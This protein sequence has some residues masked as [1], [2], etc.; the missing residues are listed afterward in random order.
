MSEYGL[1][2]YGLGPW[3]GITPFAE[4]S[5]GGV[6]VTSTRSV[7][8]FFTEVPLHQ[9][10]IIDKDA[11]NPASW[12]ILREDTGGFDDF[13]KGL[14]V[15][16]VVEIAP[17]IFEIFTLEEFG[18]YAVAHVVLADILAEDGITPI[19]D[20]YYAFFNGLQEAKSGSNTEGTIDIANPPFAENVVAGTLITG[21]DGDYVNDGG[22]PFLRKL[23][24]RR[25]CALPGGFF[26][27]DPTYGLGI[28]VKEPLRTTDLRR[29]S[30]DI[31]LQVLQEPEF[32]SVDVKLTINPGLGVL[33]ILVNAILAKSNRQ[34]SLSIPMPVDSK[35][36]A[37]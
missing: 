30:A 1:T 4:I 7:V 3:G 6:V 2:P 23:I 32:V 25:L 27:L 37:L 36:I 8:V 18:P 26:Y 22:I 17:Y 28:R 31:Q 11:L 21:T 15:V 12:Y 16:A 24:F 10:P 19:S 34:V 9:S 13:S 33:T 29:L 5:V 35:L 14:T 20:P